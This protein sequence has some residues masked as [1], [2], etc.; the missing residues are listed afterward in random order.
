MNIRDLR[1]LVAVAESKNFRLAAE[2]CFVS[3]PTLSM[4]LKKLEEELG[5]QCFERTNK[6]VLVTSAGEALV[7]H[8]Q[9]ILRQVDELR[10]IASTMSDPYAGEFRLGI[11]PTIAPYYLPTLLKTVKKAM[12]NLIPIVVEDKTE[13]LAA[14]LQDGT[15]DAVLSAL[16]ISGDNFVIKDIMTESFVLAH[17]KNHRL[18]KQ[19]SVNL[20]DLVDESLLLLD[21]GHC[22]RDQALSVCQ[23]TGLKERPGFQATS[24]ETLVRLVSSGVGVTLLPEMAVASYSKDVAI[25]SIS[26]PVPTRV[27]GIAW[28]RASVRQLCCEKIVTALLKK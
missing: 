5:V 18:K 12:P 19:V 6:K 27:I 7:D 20:S 10:A 17:A 8:A 15:L 2:H 21:D 4:Q 3:Q 13:K 9:L 28:R 11:I 25:T 16:P 22:L 24:L 1:Y 26:D 14:M 23:L